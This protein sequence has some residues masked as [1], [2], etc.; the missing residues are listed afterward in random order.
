MSSP[1]Q[2]KLSNTDEM[3]QDMDNEKTPVRQ[4]VENGKTPV[5]QEVEN[6]ISE[7]GGGE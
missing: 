2:V 1:V 6:E 5:K 3:T 7:A 4:V